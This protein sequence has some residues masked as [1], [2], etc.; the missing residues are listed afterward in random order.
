M[1]QRS[2]L[3]YE[4][5]DL[6]KDYGPRTVLQ[7]GHLQFHPG[8]IYGIVGAIGSGKT[9]LLK[10]MAGIERQTSGVLKYDGEEFKTTWLGK[11]KPID[12]IYLASVETLPESQK[13]GQ[14]VAMVHPKK[15]DKIKGRYFSRGRFREFWDLQLKNLSPGEASWFK[16]VL[17]V[18]SDPRVLLIDDYGTTM[19]SAMER[20]FR[21]KLTKMNRDLGTTIILAAPDDHRIKKFASV[22]IHLDNGHVAKIRPGVS[23]SSKRY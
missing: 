14:I 19:D 4:I 18:E 8:T 22:I 17:A 13:L 21:G 1:N 12:E 2:K 16:K 5:R 10:I 23:R 15:V 11:V 20:D 7:I 6:K 3:I 9:T